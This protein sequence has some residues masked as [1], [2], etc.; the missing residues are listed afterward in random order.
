MS[1]IDMPHN[2]SPL[3]FLSFINCCFWTRWPSRR[4]FLFATV[5][6]QEGLQ[7]EKQQ[8]IPHVCF[9]RQMLIFKT[10]HSIISNK[11]ETRTGVSEGP[12]VFGPVVQSR[13]AHALE[14]YSSL[15][16]RSGPDRYA[17]S[18]YA[19]APSRSPR[20]PRGLDFMLHRDNASHVKMCKAN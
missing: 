11:H 5:N 1:V 3:L 18:F 2:F 19:P 20:T 14:V 4:H 12:A 13:G 17:P 10:F 16:L 8:W 7:Q 6:A 9:G 15:G